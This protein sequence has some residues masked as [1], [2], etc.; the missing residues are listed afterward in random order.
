MLD[1][2]RDGEF[3]TGDQAAAWQEPVGRVEIA[4]ADVLNMES[5]HRR[6]V[7]WQAEA[8]LRGGHYVHVG[9]GDE[10]PHKYQAYCFPYDEMCWD[11]P[12]RVSVEEAVSDGR[13]HNPGFE[14][15][16]RPWVAERDD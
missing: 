2:I 5:N 1:L 9:Y 16:L 13:K 7:I 10:D 12:D 15:E 3:R 11:G 8:D 14:P 4:M 6:G